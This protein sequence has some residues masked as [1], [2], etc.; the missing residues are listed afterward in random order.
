M[1]Q[2]ADRQYTTYLAL[3]GA[4]PESTGLT[5]THLRVDVWH[6]DRK[7]LMLTV[8]GVERHP[9]GKGETHLLFSDRTKRVPLEPAPRFNRKK[10]IDWA[11]RV[12]ESI[13]QEYGGVW[14]V[15]TDCRMAH[16]ASIAK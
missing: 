4:K 9:D 10:L 15:I 14:E 3:T 7:A 12:Q 11:T 6:H 16:G 13:T 5:A 1:K 2:T 8:A